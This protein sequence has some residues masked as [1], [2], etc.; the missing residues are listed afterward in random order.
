MASAF[1]GPSYKTT[2]KMISLPK[3]SMMLP[4]LCISLST[5]AQ[6]DY[7]SDIPCYKKAL[8]DFYSLYEPFPEHRPMLRKKPNGWYVSYLDINDKETTVLY[9]KKGGKQYE[10]LPFRKRAL[11][12]DMEAIKE[13]VEFK[14]KIDDQFNFDRC[15]FYGYDQWSWD[16]IQTYGKKNDLSEREMESLARAQA[17]YAN[18]FLPYFQYTHIANPG[19]P[20][21]KELATGKTLSSIRLDS[22]LF[23]E[24]QC[25]DMYR[26]LA[27]K[28]PDYSTLVGNVYC[29]LNNEHMDIYL[30]L[31]YIHET[32]KANAY[33]AKCTYPKN[34]LAT[35]YNYLN[36]LP[37]HAILISHGDNDTYPLWYLQATKNFRTDVAV[38]NNS[39]LGVSPF[40]QLV[41]DSLRKFQH[42]L[43]DTN[44][45]HLHKRYMSCDEKMMRPGDEFHVSDMLRH[46]ELSSDSI[47]LFKSGRYFVDCSGTNVLVYK[48]QYHTYLEDLVLYDIIDRNMAL[49]PI[50]FTGSYAIPNGFM[51]RKMQTGRCYQIGCDLR[52][53]QVDGSSIMQFFRNGYHAY[54]AD[55]SYNI[56]LD[57]TLNI[58]YYY[59]LQMLNNAMLA[60]YARDST[61]RGSLNELYGM[62]KNIWPDAWHYE[63]ALYELAA[64]LYKTGMLAEARELR[65]YIEQEVERKLQ[66][67]ISEDEAWHYGDGERIFYFD[68]YLQSLM[69][70]LEDAAYM[71][72][73]QALEVLLKKVKGHSQRG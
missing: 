19:S 66:V 71:E 27:R 61:D 9:R 16:V 54:T 20:F 30:K 57:K 32:T 68:Y 43:I 22:F 24:D 47:L 67:S 10:A 62:A 13:L 73:R 14:E 39:L 37:E 4:L 18:G 6:T 59:Y 42:I 1:P 28:N 46:A 69:Y 26:K 45:F 31:L 33:L 50:F 44:L 49:R 11:T 56:A 65:M 21:R 40:L 64:T 51:N 3:I 5:A 23:Y 58:N 52:Q 34:I 53:E 41:S 8:L 36:G 70:V 29:K 15:A 12:L 48:D 17:H 60:V 7:F 63:E 25:L 35:A 55:T 38:L 72:D 2:L